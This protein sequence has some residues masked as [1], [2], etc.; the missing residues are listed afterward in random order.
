[1]L[2]HH[3]KGKVGKFRVVKLRKE[4]GFKS[5][6]IGKK[7]LRDKDNDY[8]YKLERSTHPTNFSYRYPSVSRYAYQ[9]RKKDLAV[10][11]TH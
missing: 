4:H 3:R 9:Y 2:E 10:K 6:V 1:M 7:V 8:T 11:Q 5:Y